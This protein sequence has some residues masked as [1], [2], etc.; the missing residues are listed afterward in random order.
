MLHPII[1]KLLAQIPQSFILLLQINLEIL[2]E[3]ALSFNEIP[4]IVDRS[5]E[6]AM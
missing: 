4:E 2:N 3:L 1:Q 6:L 5:E